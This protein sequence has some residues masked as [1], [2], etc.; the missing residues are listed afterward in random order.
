MVPGNWNQ[1]HVIKEEVS[2]LMRKG[3]TVIGSTGKL[4]YS[5]E[6]DKLVGQLESQ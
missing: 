6:G 2:K 4:T 1:I 5:L 3:G